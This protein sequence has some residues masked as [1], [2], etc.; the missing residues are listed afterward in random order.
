M[1]PL[2]ISAK[3]GITDE[4]QALQKALDTIQES[5]LRNHKYLSGQDTPNLGDLAVFGTLRSVDGLPVHVR[6]MSKPENNLLSSWYDRM[7]QHIS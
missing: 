2:I 3:R 7:K 4:V 5:G 6:I 1:I